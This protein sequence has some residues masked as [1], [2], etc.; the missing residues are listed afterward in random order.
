MHIDLNDSKARE[1]RTDKLLAYWKGKPSEW[2]I[3]HGILCL[4]HFDF[5][6]DLDKLFNN[7]RIAERLD[8]INTLE[9]L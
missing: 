2:R 7:I 5:S 8:T 9:G 6:E 3:L 1:I 4:S